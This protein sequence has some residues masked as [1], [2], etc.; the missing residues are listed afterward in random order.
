MDASKISLNA[1]KTRWIQPA[2]GGL[3]V[4]VMA[5]FVPQVLGVGYSYV[6]DAL[7]SRMTIEIMALLVVLKVVAT[8]SSY[9][10]GNAG[11]IFGPSLFIGAMMGGTIG[12]LAHHVFPGITANAGAYALVGMGAAFAGIVRVPLTSVIMIFEMTRDYS[13]IVPLMI[14]NLI[15]FYISVRLQQQP[16]YEALA[17][18]D[19][20]HL[21][22]SHTRKSAHHLR[23]SAA[24]STPIAVIPVSMSPSE[25]LTQLNAV[26][27][28]ELPVMDGEKFLGMI[29]KA[30]LSKCDD[31]T[32]LPQILGDGEFPHLHPDHTI[33]IALY[34]MGSHNVKQLPVVS[35]RD[36]H[37]LEGVVTLDGVLR[38]YGL[39]PDDSSLN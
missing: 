19:G 2:A 18:Q 33:D 1:G 39:N 12:G 3:L 26:H 20:V 9:A 14:A 31:T 25:A 13:I 27:E 34:R 37:Q 8:T 36:L 28:L 30:K 4:G 23:V 35:R 32:D 16:I 10:S 29:S 22:N 24:A 6:G 38:L 11:G 21:P 15:S 17:A 5:W 7:N